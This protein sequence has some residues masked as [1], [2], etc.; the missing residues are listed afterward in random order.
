MDG[1][2]ESGLVLGWGK[3]KFRKYILEHFIISQAC[4]PIINLK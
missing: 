3:K 1:A 4:Y 2:G